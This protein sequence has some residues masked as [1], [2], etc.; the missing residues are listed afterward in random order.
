MC[1]PFSA[2]TCGCGSLPP[3]VLR[4]YFN[5]TTQPKIT[6]ERNS[7]RTFWWLHRYRRNTVERK[8]ELDGSDSCLYSADRRYTRKGQ[9]KRARRD[10]ALYTW[11][12]GTAVKWA[13][14]F[15]KTSYTTFVRYKINDRNFTFRARLIT[16]AQRFARYCTR[17]V[18]CVAC[19][20]RLMTTYTWRFVS[21]KWLLC[22]PEAS[23]HRTHMS[24]EWHIKLKSLKTMFSAAGTPL[25][26]LITYYT[27]APKTLLQP[28]RLK[29]HCSWKHGLMVGWLPPFYGRLLTTST[30]FPPP[31]SPGGTKP[32]S[33]TARK[34]NKNAQTLSPTCTFFKWTILLDSLFFR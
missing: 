30:P 9:Q 13:S 21:E 20:H 8:V 28:N 23:V 12:V 19:T 26:K 22:F 14:E 31:L 16:I 24:K 33:K 11:I 4:K 1:V 15:Y 10:S 7:L 3:L 2:F 17:Q 34:K 5:R 6:L 29:R 27:T 32:F 18:P 25:Q